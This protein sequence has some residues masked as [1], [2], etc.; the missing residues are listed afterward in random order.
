MKL[1]GAPGTLLAC[2]IARDGSL[3]AIEGNRYQLHT[4][5]GFPDQTLLQGLSR[6]INCLMITLYVIAAGILRHSPQIWFDSLVRSIIF[7]KEFANL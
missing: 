3:C 6:T 1:G 5:S 4:E 7:P 2:G